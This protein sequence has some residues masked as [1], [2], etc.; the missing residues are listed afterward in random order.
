MTGWRA[1]G[2]GAVGIAAA[3]LPWW[4]D[5][6]TTATATRILALALLAGSVVVLTGHAGLPTLGQTAPFAVGGYT[7]ALLARGGHT[8][9]IGQLAASAVAAALFAAA[10]GVLT[11]HTRATVHLMVTVAVG[12]LT[13]IAADQAG[14]L[15]GGTDGIS[16]LPPTRPLPG[17]PE[18]ADDRQIYLYALA[19]AT[20]GLTAT[21]VLLRGP[22]GRLLRA[23]RDHEPRARASGHPVNRYLYTAH[24]AAAVLAGL[25]GSLLVTAQ[26]AITPADAGFDTASISLLATALGGAGSIAGAATGTALIIV[27]RDVVAGPFAGHAPLLLGCLYIGCVYLLPGGLAGLAG[28]LAR[29]LPGRL[30]TRPAPAGDPPPDEPAARAAARVTDRRAHGAAPDPPTLLRA[31]GLTRT[32]A[33]LTALDHLDLELTTGARHAVL[34]PNGAGKTTLLH[35]LAGTTQATSGTITF[36]G[37][38]ISRQPAHRRARLGLV[39]TFQHPAAWPRHST[40][41]NVIL[42]AW[43]HRHTA[44]QHLP[45]DARHILDEVGLTTQAAVPAGTLSHGQRRLLE[46]AIALAA[47]P[48]LLL[49]DEPA[50]GLTPAD[51]DRLITVLR[52]L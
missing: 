6:Y 23:V 48:R 50:A 34:G 43:P 35:L 7:T 3:T 30:R 36:A 49:L 9:G 8:A 15:T 10:T 14:A 20:A 17:L 25:G 51:T 40:L 18:L 32:Y 31:C 11:V 19:V 47:R 29:R 27:T 16:F 42:G 22:A 37:H 13:V 44:R 28:A 46:I 39:R 52:A 4:V 26:H 38:D 2:V 24:V 5:P 21:W 41:D 33:S 45:A 12:Q 1:G